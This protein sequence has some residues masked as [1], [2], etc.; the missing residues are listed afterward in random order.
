MRLFSSL[1][2][3]GV[4]I[5]APAAAQLLTS[6]PAPGTLR[7][8]AV[9][10]VD[11]G[12]CGADQIKQ[13]IGGNPSKG[14][15]RQVSCVNRPERRHIHFIHMGGNDCPPCRVWRALELPKLQASPLFGTI[16]YSYVTKAIG[17][18]VPPEAFL[19]PEVK[20]LKAK[21]DT[22]SS[23]R[24]GSPHQVLVVDGEV[25]DYWFGERSAEEIL[26]SVQAIATGAKYPFSRCIKRSGT[27]SGTCE[28]K[29]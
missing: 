11:D 21:L 10:Y 1:A 13:V 15:R 23:G 27:K 17:S 19:P 6:E 3:L 7:A 28:I 14:I 22:A 9:V 12:S 18:P 16:T 26:A 8:G 2:F 24:N 20:P 4:F 25:Y 5:S 29:G